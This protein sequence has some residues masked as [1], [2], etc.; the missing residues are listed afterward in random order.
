M[1]TWFHRVATDRLYFIHHRSYNI[2]YRYFFFYLHPVRVIAPPHSF[3]SPP[4]DYLQSHTHTHTAFLHLPTVFLLIRLAT[5]QIMNMTCN[6]ENIM[7]DML[8]CMFTLHIYIAAL[9]S[10]T[11]CSNAS[12]SP[13]FLPLSKLSLVVCS[14]FLSWRVIK[15]RMMDGVKILFKIK[16]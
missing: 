2:K 15:K 4:S 5:N 13:V 16:V 9:H 8:T 10:L 3:R 14:I 6:E 11:R 7:T 1:N 12:I